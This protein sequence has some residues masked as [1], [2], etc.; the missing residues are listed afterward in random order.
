MEKFCIEEIYVILKMEWSEKNARK[1]FN[2]DVGL[3]GKKVIIRDS[4]PGNLNE[5]ILLSKTIIHY[6]VNN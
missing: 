6:Q 3:P 5:D 2:D 1:A 4:S